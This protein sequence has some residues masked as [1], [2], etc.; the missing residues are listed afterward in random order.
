MAQRRMFSKKVIDTDAFLDMPTSTQL[1]YFHLALHADD[2]GFVSSPKKIIRTIGSNN[3]DLKVLLS[4][5]F[6]I[7]F[8]TGVCVIKHWRIHNYIQSDRYSKTT[9]IDELSKLKI[10]DNG[11]YT[12]CIHDVSVLEPQVRLGKV[13]KG[14]VSKEG[15]C[16][17]KKPSLK[18]IVDYCAERKS[19]VDPESFFDYYES[20]GWIKANG[21][22][23]KDWKAT[24]RTWEKK[25]QKECDPYAS[26]PKL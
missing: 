4:K 13:S 19:A 15:K 14:K 9:Y 16:F 5:R 10:K 7:G 25:N 22:K 8:E 6:I 17:F 3:D 20:S 18:A 21:Q 2:D 24:I 26:M 1:L 12:E 11:S 23:V